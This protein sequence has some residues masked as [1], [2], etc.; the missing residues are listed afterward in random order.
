VRGYDAAE[1]ARNSSFARTSAMIKYALEFFFKGD[2]TCQRNCSRHWRSAGQGFR[3]VCGGGAQTKRFEVSAAAASARP[4]WPHLSLVKQARPQGTREPEALK[5]AAQAPAPAEPRPE[6]L[7]CAAPQ[8]RAPGT[9]GQNVP[10]S[11]VRRQRPAH[12]RPAAFGEWFNFDVVTLVLGPFLFFCC[13][14]TCG[15]CC[16]QLYSMRAKY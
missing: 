4:A 14:C 9:Q 11:P 7:P 5:V 2:F 15:L 1:V 10:E 8:F 12:A 3:C 13:A 6:A 16:A